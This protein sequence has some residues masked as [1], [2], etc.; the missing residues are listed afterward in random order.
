MDPIFLIVFVIVLALLFDFTNGFNDAANAIA[1]AVGTRVMTPRI[2]VAMSASLN[3]VG[4]LV[5]TAVAATVAGKI[6]DAAEVT[7]VT[8]IS[9]LLAASGW[10]VVATYL[11]L[12]VSASH[13]LMS[14]LVGAGIATAG[15]SIVK[16]ASVVKIVAA[17]LVSP[18]VGFILSFLVLTILTIAFRNSSPSKVT[19][20][21]KP[22]QVISSAYMSFSHGSNDAQ[23]TMGV[24]TLALFTGG[25]IPELLVPLW[26]KIAAATAMGLGTALGGWRVIKTLGMSLTKLRPIDGFSAEASSATVIWANSLLGLPISTTHVVSSS[27]MGVGASKRFSSVRWGVGINIILAWIFTIPMCAALAWGLVRIINLF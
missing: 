7:Q 9:A 15:L 5:G 16:W 23:K 3:L 14:S 21:F 24:I 10:N 6:L 4:A 11:G 13:A 17:L 18:I 12:P 20:I 27:I 25:M 19:R 1:T 22:A 26:V 2:A 8:V